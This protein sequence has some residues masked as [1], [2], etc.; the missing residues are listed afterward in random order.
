MRFYT[1]PAPRLPTASPAAGVYPEI[2]RP[3]PSPRDT[4][5]PRPSDAGPSHLLAPRPGGQTTTGDQH[6][7]GFPA[8]A[9]VC[10]RSGAVLQGVRLREYP[11]WVLEGDIKGCFDNIDHDWLLPERPDGPNG[12]SGSG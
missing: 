3:A 11:A 2:E 7:Y 9:I 1:P 12:A 10:G 5:D 4:D 8:G 6:S